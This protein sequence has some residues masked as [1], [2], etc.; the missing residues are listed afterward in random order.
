MSGW[1]QLC[2]DLGKRLLQTPDDCTEAAKS[3][4]LE[5]KNNSFSNH[6]DDHHHD[7]KDD[8]DDN[9]SSGCFANRYNEAYWNMQRTGEHLQDIREV[10]QNGKKH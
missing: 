2:A 1:G 4:G 9:D 3:L 6:P 8:D 7:E 10:C 5:Y